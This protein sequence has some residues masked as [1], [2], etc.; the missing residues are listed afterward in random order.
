MNTELRENQTNKESSNP[1]TTQTAENSPIQTSFGKLPICTYCIL[2]YFL[3][4][5]FFK[6][7]TSCSNLQA[8]VYLAHRARVEEACS[9]CNFNCTLKSIAMSW[10]EDRFFTQ[11]KCVE[12]FKWDRS[13]K[14][15]L[16]VSWDQ[17]FEGWFQDRADDGRTYAERF[18]ELWDWG[19]KHLS[20]IAI[21]QLVVGSRHSYRTT[22][23]LLRA[24]QME[25]KWR[26]RIGI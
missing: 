16:E 20:D 13:K 5:K 8:E 22:I 6:K 3:T 7:A 21:Y 11:L 9:H 14:L 1:P 19:K 23:D 25:E 12:I 26:E 17:A 18:C 24:L 4:P 10:Y 15:G 2:E